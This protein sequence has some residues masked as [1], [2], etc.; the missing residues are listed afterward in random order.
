MSSSDWAIWAYHA[1]IVN[2]GTNSGNH[3]YAIVAGPG[4]ELEVIGVALLNG[5]ATDRQGTL[6]FEDEEPDRL[7][8]AFSRTHSAGT[9][10]GFPY[11]EDD[12]G[13]GLAA[14]PPYSIA[15]VMA[16]RWTLASVAVSQDSALGIWGRIREGLPTVT[17]T[18]PTDA[19]ETVNKNQVY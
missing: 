16:L 6:E 2:D 1:D 12:F 14:G 3:V 4:N 7:G 10:V 19:V 18:S 15:G 13:S 5:D 11:A 9:I 8:R 17:L